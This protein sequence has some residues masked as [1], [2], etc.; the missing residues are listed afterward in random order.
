MCTESDILEICNS[1]IEM[2][3]FLS[4]TIIF[5]VNMEMKLNL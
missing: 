5:H 4:T 2:D 1:G 3:L